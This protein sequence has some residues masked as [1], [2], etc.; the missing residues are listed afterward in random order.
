MPV[1]LYFPLHYTN[2]NTATTDSRLTAVCGEEIPIAPLDAVVVLDPYVELDALGVL[3][4]FVVL[5]ALGAPDV[6]DAAVEEVVVAAATAEEDDEVLGT[7][8]FAC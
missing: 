1:L 4:A 8:A 2:R 5:D 6:V 7:T 3:D